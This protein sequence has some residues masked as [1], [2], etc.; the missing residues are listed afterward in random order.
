MRFHMEA[1]MREENSELHIHDVESR[2]TT[3][4]HRQ[5]VSSPGEEKDEVVLNSSISILCRRG[6]RGRWHRGTFQAATGSIVG[7]GLGFPDHRRLEIGLDGVAGAQDVQVDKVRQVDRIVK[8]NR[9]TGVTLF[10]TP[11]ISGYRGVR[12]LLLVRHSR[13]CVRRQF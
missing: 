13:G 7:N 3:R 12:L 4:D 11:W 2:R 8:R 5:H 9:M 1:R 10:V 6:V